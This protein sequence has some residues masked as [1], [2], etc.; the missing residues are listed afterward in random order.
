MALGFGIMA[1]INLSAAGLRSG[2]GKSAFM[3][4]DIT[5]MAAFH[6]CVLVWLVYLY[7][8]DRTAAFT[9][10]GLAKSDIQVWDQE[11]QRITGR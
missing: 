10:S 1:C 6:L 11:L 7:L 8:P 3:A 2:L 5:Q 4:V 9:G